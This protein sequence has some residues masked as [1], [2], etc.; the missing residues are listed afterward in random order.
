MSGY[1]K[2]IVLRVLRLFFSR[3]YGSMLMSSSFSIML[4]GVVI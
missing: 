2:V 1:V 3:L 4:L